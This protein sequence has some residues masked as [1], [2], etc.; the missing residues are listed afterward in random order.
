LWSHDISFRLSSRRLGYAL[1]LRL[2]FSLTR[3][4][5]CLNFLF[6]LLLLELLHLLARVSVTTR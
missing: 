4:P 1:S 5:L 3:R 2:L 6:S